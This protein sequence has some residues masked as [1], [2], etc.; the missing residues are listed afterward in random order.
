MSDIS[1]PASPAHHTAP[2]SHPLDVATRLELNEQGTLTGRPHAAY[3]N[4]VGPFGGVTAAILLNAALTH[5]ARLGDPVSLTVNYAGPVA[6][7]DFEVEAVPVRTNRSTQHWTILQTQ[8]GEVVTSASAVFAVRRETWSSTEVAFPDVPPANDVPAVSYGSVVAWTHNYDMR[9]LRGPL[10]DTSRPPEDRDSVSTLWLRDE[11]PRP[12]DF[13][14]LAALCDA[15]FP[16]IMVRR[17]QRVPFGTVS[18]TCHFHADAALLAAQ[19]D[20]ALLGT[21]RASRFGLG[22]HDQSA[23]LW[24]DTGHLLATTHQIVYFKE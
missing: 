12:L 24:S 18:I 20:R 17:P 21:A 23:E 3:A 8:A 19:G 7:G 4:L 10:L 15:F 14:S 13:V 2:P 5:P 6:D 11:P 22:Y 1:E 9:F 16:R